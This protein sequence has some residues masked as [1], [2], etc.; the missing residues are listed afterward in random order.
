MATQI[1]FVFEFY[2]QLT[3]LNFGSFAPVEG[4]T[5]QVRK[6]YSA[7]QYFCITAN[8]LCNHHLSFSFAQRA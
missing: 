4:I 3:F 1:V 2:D 5:F 8:N 7:L 6:Y